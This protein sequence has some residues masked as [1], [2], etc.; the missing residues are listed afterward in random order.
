MYKTEENE[1]V[2]DDPEELLE[3]TEIIEPADIE[4]Y[5]KRKMKNVDETIEYEDEQEEFEDFVI[6]EDIEEYEPLEE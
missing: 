1:E 6:D 4:E 2:F 3:D 5:K